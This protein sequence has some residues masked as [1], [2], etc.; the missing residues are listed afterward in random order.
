M[1]DTHAGEKIMVM[2]IEY[3]EVD[4]QHVWRFWV[5]AYGTDKGKIVNYETLYDPVKAQVIFKLY[6]EE[7]YEN[8][9]KV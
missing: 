7:N 1:A 9:T 3:H 4:V 8:K 5:E 6:V 2:K